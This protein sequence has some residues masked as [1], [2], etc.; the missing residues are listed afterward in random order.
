MNQAEKDHTHEGNVLIKEFVKF[1]DENLEEDDDKNTN[2][3]EQVDNL[4]NNSKKNLIVDTINIKESGDDPNTSTKESNSKSTPIR[5]DNIRREAFIAPMIFLKDYFIQNFDL[6]FASF[7]CIDVFGYKLSDWKMILGLQIYQI[8][9][10]YPEN[11]IKIIEHLE[12][13][14][15]N[16]RKLLFYYLMT[17]TY[18]EIYTRYITG[19]INFPIIKDGYLRITQ[20]KTLKKVVL[21]KNEKLNKN[22]Y[23]RYLTEQ[24]KIEIYEKLSK[25]MIDDI[26]GGKLERKGRKGGKGKEKQEKERTFITFVIKEFEIKRNYF[27]GKNSNSGI[28]L[29]E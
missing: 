21:E 12:S 7:N 14:L 1:V 3:K 2:I 9:C 19:D 26:K 28:E 10:Y 20:F 29:Q 11:Y 22:E 15:N 8:F 16:G 5:I 25:N 27:D 6:D 13:G 18:E 17:R 23:E 4:E 24:K